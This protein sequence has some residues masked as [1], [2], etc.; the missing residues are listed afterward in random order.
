M[1][2]T[3]A[4]SAPAASPSAVKPSA[5]LDYDAFLR[6]LVTQMKNQDP[7]N[8]MD[9][10]QYMAQFAQFSQVEQSIKTNAKLDSIYASL[11]L[12]NVDGLI[13]R[14][15]TLPDGTGGTVA[16]VKITAE[17]PEAVLTSGAVVTLGEGVVLS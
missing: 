11:S 2:V 1:I 4:T 13:G 5:D 12:A 10:S 14:T 8:P 16:S 6:L 15:V 7:I 9:S 17:G 3:S